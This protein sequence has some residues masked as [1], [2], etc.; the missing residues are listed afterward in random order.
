MTQNHYAAKLDA[1]ASTLDVI[2]GRLGISRQAVA[3]HIAEHNAAV[4]AVQATAAAA[5][6]NRP[7]PVVSNLVTPAGAQGA[8]GTS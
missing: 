5:V 2:A 4:S 3:D 7:V 1:I 6:S 8:T